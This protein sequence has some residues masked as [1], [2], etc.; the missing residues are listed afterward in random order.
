MSMASARLMLCQFFAADCNLLSCV[1]G[2]LT[3]AF[4]YKTVIFPL[5]NFSLVY[6]SFSKIVKTNIDCTPSA[7]TPSIFFNC[8]TNVIC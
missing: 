7:L 1:I 8:Q 4:F 5:E 2:S 6:M 3:L